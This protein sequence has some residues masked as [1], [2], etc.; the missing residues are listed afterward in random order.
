MI[1]KQ[2]VIDSIK[3]VEYWHPEGTSLTVCCLVFKNGF[4]QTGESCASNPK[5]FNED[6]GKQFAYDDAITKSFK[7]FAWDEANSR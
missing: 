5:E 6:L 3:R 2:T 4:V 7:Y 1:D